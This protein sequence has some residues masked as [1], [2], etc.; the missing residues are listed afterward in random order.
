MS[1]TYRVLVIDDNKTIHEDFRKVLSHR[2]HSSNIKSVKESVFGANNSHVEEIFL[3]SFEIDTASQGEEGLSYVEKSLEERKP[4][5]LMFVDIRMPPGW[6]GV[7]TIH[8]IWKIDP[9]IQTVICTAYSDYS[10]DEIVKKLGHTDRLLILKKPF[11]NIEVLQFALSLT[12][13]WKLEQAAKQQVI[14]LNKLV[15]KKTKEVMTSLSITKAILESIIEG[16]LVVNNKGEIINC[17]QKLIDIWKL[18][19]DWLDKKKFSIFLKYINEMVIDNGITR[20]DERVKGDL[21]D[22]IYYEIKLKNNAILE[23]YSIPHR[24]NN[25]IIGRV[26]SFHVVT[27]RRNIESQLQHLATFDTLTELPNRI[28][29]I[30]RIRQAIIDSQR[31]G[32]F[33]AILFIDID[34]FKNINDTLGHSIGD[35]LLTEIAIRLKNHIRESDTLAR[36]GGDEFVIVLTDLTREESIVNVIKKLIRTIALPYQI[37]GREVEVTCS[38][39]VCF[40]PRDG[41]TAETVLEN[42][43]IAMYKVKASGRN[44]YKFYSEDMTGNFTQRLQLENDFSKAIMNNELVLQYQPVV[45]INTQEIV[46]TDVDVVWCHPKLGRI[47][48]QI[49][50]SIAKDI[51][52]ISKVGE[53]VLKKACEINKKL[54]DEGVANIPIIVNVSSY[55]FTRSMI[56]TKIKN[57]LVHSDLKPEYLVIAFNESNLLDNSPDVIHSLEG[58]E[59]IN[60]KVLMSNFGSGY[61]SLNSLRTL[62]ISK[63]KIDKMFVKQINESQDNSII[64]AIINLAH[65][66]GIKVIADGVDTDDQMAFLN[67]NKCDEVQG[68][69]VSPL[70]D[71]EEYTQFLLRHNKR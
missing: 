49:F 36:L 35:G 4:Y 31:S 33:F 13:K 8:R 25:T 61:T 21:D 55:Y 70:L 12:E 54:Q 69:I 10:R 23:C 45:D 64:I 71:L 52:L 43:D 44:N 56:V 30:E 14:I 67:K 46:S 32:K 2:S 1:D 57:T 15:K 48:P 42:A 29:L 28:L 53:W 47:P 51:G 68:E 58:L 40:Y 66:L 37:H 24:I 11:D 20:S 59:K 27:E 26:M 18:P 38:I 22:E 65:S 19:E 16:I 3:P 7:E 60:V 9:E 62:P 63:L 50:I 17:N 5:S 41:V 34:R 39:G 6:D